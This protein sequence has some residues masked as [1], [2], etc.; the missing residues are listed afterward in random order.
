MIRLELLPSEYPQDASN[1]YDVGEKTLDYV[2]QL[3]NFQLKLQAQFDVFGDVPSFFS[4]WVIARGAKSF[5]NFVEAGALSNPGTE[6]QSASAAM[7][8]VN[9]VQ[10]ENSAVARIG[11]GTLVNQAAGLVTAGEEGLQDVAVTATSTAKAIN[12]ARTKDPRGFLDKIDEKLNGVFDEKVVGQLNK[13]VAPIKKAIEGL[14]EK[15][16]KSLSGVSEVN[17]YLK[18]RE[19]A[20][21]KQQTNVG[22]K[23]LSHQ[24]YRFLGVIFPVWLRP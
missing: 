8:A 20:K 15:L 5:T 3:E 14:V 4:N 12:W 13:A 7:L 9:A 23:S 16:L 2:D 18:Q 11:K 22:F 21:T 17:G 6:T 1:P 24:F 19:E 10:V